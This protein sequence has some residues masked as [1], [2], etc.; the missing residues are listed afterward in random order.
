MRRGRV[1]FFALPRG[2]GQECDA[3]RGRVA[4]TR[5]GWCTAHVFGDSEGAVEGAGDQRVLCGVWDHGGEGYTEQCTYLF[6]IRWVEQAVSLDQN[7]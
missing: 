2:H 7:T 5:K 4:A 3:D 1:Q 6:D